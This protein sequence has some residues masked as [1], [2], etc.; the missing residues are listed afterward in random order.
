MSFFYFLLSHIT[1]VNHT[2]FSVACMARV[3]KAFGHFVVVAGGGCRLEELET[4]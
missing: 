4:R 3:F 1:G 2:H